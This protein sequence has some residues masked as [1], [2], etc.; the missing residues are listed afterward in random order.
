MF[1]LNLADLKFAPLTDKSHHKNNCID[2]HVDILFNLPFINKVSSS[3][4]HKLL[5]IVL[6]S[7]ST[8]EAWGYVKDKLSDLFLVKLI[9]KRLDPETRDLIENLKNSYGPPSCDDLIKFLIKRTRALEL[10]E[11]N[12]KFLQENAKQRVSSG[13]YNIICPVTKKPVEKISIVNNNTELLPLHPSKPPELPKS[14]PKVMSNLQVRS[15]PQSLPENPTKTNKNPRVSKN[16]LTKTED[17]NRLL[18]NPKRTSSKSSE[19]SSTGSSGSGKDEILNK[20]KEVLLSTAIVLVNDSKGRFRHCR[21]LLDS[22]D[23]F[24]QTDPDF[25]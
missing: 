24:F 19:T 14:E 23:S 12:M 9:T 22:T 8:L 3:E 10:I 20:D 18:E 21:T 15:N 5:S 17:N 16:C 7:L 25:L 13:E 11:I 6:K 1:P 2:M 4:L